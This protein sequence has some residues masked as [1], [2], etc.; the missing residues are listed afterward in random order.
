MYQ[1][2]TSNYLQRNL[3]VNKLRE[4]RW[5]PIH[6]DRQT[7][8]ARIANDLKKLGVS[9]FGLMMAESKYLPKIIQSDEP[10]TGVVYGHH[11]D[12]YAMLVATDRRVIFLDKKPLFT[13]QDDID[14]GVV[15]GVSN[16]HGTFANTVTLHT[17]VKDYAIKT[18]NRKCALGFVRFI[19]NLIEYPKRAQAFNYR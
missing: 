16:G 6:F 12:G 10:I 13:N 9:K 1:L 7:H 4:R 8:L 15:S 2:P 5:Q 3:Q 14:Y 11:E 19:E 18:H 17:R